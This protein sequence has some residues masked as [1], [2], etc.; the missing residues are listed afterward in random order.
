MALWWTVL[1][2][3]IALVIAQSLG[4][5]RGYRNRRVPHLG[6]LLRNRAPRAWAWDGAAVVGILLMFQAAYSLSGTEDPS[7]SI[8]G[9]AFVL[10][11]IGQRMVVLVHNR[12]VPPM[13]EQ[14]SQAN[15]APLDA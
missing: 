12:R 6:F 10:S 9:G 1:G 5:T 7:W 11:F 3:G 2:V 13:S 4:L 14:T 8:F 15:D